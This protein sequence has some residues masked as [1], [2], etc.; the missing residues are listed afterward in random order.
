M[1]YGPLCKG[2]SLNQVKATKHTA[3]PGR[4]VDPAFR[5]GAG[6]TG[7]GA[8]ARPGSRQT[9][10]GHPAGAKVDPAVENARYARQTG[11]DQ[12]FHKRANAGRKARPTGPFRRAYAV[13]ISRYDWQNEQ[14]VA[15]ACLW[16][17]RHA[18]FRRIVRA[19]AGCGAILIHESAGV[20][21]CYS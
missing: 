8:G 15:I 11:H 7:K 17:G 16:T 5:P 3:G 13:E 12:N 4:A 20:L 10:T 14:Y 18:G 19:M 2:Q 21:E 1:A 9:T 6:L